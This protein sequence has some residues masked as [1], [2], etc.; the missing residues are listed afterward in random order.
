MFRMVL[1]FGFFVFEDDFLF[2]YVFHLWCGWIEFED[3]HVFGLVV[4]LGFVESGEGFLDGEGLFVVFARVLR[5]K[6]FF[7]SN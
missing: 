4:G 7:I 6:G 2:F 1:G 5:G 3:G